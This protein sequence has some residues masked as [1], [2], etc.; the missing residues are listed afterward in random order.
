MKLRSRIMAIA[1]ALQLTGCSSNG[2][3][4]LPADAIASVGHNVLT[5]RELV[6]NMPAGLSVD[7]STAFAKA[8]IRRWADAH[9][10]EA[11]AASEIDIEQ[12]DRLTREYRL[13]LIMNQYRRAMASQADG[14]FSDDSLMAY[15][16]SHK[17]AFRLERPMLKGIYI[18]LPSDAQ[19]LKQIKR[20]YRSDKAED[21]DRLEKEANSA[22]IHYDYFRDRWIDWEQIETRIPMDFTAADVNVLS[23]RRWLEVEAQGFIYLLSVSEFL[24]AQATMPFDAAKS[25]V[26]ERLLTQRRNAYD[27]VLRD[28]L[29][30]SSLESG[31]LVFY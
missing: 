17:S 5:R 15:Y 31:V 12:I 8:Y 4:A 24:P 23:S 19:N 16:E 25:V 10:I 20:L 6:S 28:S 2:D 29:Y 21:I 1:V 11:V 30:R 27:A 22:A 7:D 26:R 13:E 3:V 18:K 9:L 14:V